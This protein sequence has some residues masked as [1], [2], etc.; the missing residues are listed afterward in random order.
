MTWHPVL[1]IPIG[2][3][4]VV[5]IF[6][7]AFVIDKLTRPEKV[8]ESD[9]VRALREFIEFQNREIRR[10][11]IGL[12]EVQR[13]KD[14]EE[15]SATSCRIGYGCGLTEEVLRAHWAKEQLYRWRSAF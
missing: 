5:A 9:A 2:F 13:W 1:W 3:G 4:A 8:E 11:C 15:P 10:L 7:A 14:G 6:I 12:P